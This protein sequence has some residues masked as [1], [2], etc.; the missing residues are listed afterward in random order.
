VVAPVT[1]RGRDTRERFNGT[2]PF[3]RKTAVDGKSL[4]RLTCM[5]SDC[6]GAIYVER[7]NWPDMPTA[8]CF[9]CSKASRLPRLEQFD[10]GTTLTP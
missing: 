9:H 2:L 5:R 1:R 7:E 6:G 4:V 8:P 10:L 3:F